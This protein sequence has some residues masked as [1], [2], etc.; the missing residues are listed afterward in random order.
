[1]T[2]LSRIALFVRCQRAHGADMIRRV[3]LHRAACVR[4]P[5]LTALACGLD[6][7]ADERIAC[8]DGIAGPHLRLSLQR[9]HLLDHAVPRRHD[10]GDSGFIQQLGLFRARMSDHSQ[11]VAPQIERK[12]CNL[13][14]PL[15]DAPADTRRIQRPD[16][17]PDVYA[18]LI[19]LAHDSG[20]VERGRDV[21]LYRPDVRAQHPAQRRRQKE[22]A[23]QHG[24]RA[25][26]LRRERKSLPPQ[27]MHAAARS[28]HVPPQC[29]ELPDGQGRVQLVPRRAL[30]PPQQDAVRRA[31]IKEPRQACSCHAHAHLSARQLPQ[32]PDHVRSSPLIR[33]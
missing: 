31:Q 23:P 19:Q 22:P 4:Q 26:P 8:G 24:A 14:L 7:P 15:H 3:R 27:D 11:A 16:G 9:A 18:Q 25:Q 10:L 28:S 30:H 33:S 1:M 32:P 5:V 2:N 21:G 17:H 29:A 13:G 20:A 6:Q 12:E